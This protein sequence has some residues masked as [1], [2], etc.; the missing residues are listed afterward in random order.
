[1]PTNLPK[2]SL[3]AVFINYFPI[4]KWIEKHFVLE[5]LQI[6]YGPLLKALE[7]IRN[8]WV[9]EN[10]T[11]HVIYGFIKKTADSTFLIA[12]VGCVCAI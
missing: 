7:K 8:E 5:E 3:S 4:G 2:P 11:I 10:K 6:S 9:W 1:M 12:L